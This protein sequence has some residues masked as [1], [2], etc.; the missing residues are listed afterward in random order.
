MWL[1]L[2]QRRLAECKGC[3]FNAVFGAMSPG[4]QP[5]LL[6]VKPLLENQS[7]A[8]LARWLVVDAKN[9]GAAVLPANAPCELAGYRCSAPSHGEEGPLTLL[10]PGA[11]L[12]LWFCP[13]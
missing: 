13:M 2:L 10:P 5:D 4:A 6:R 1:P 12:D 7:V 9:H 3:V 11:S 8:P